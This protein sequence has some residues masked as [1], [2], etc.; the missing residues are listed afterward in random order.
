MDYPNNSYYLN[1]AFG[2][3]FEVRTGLSRLGVAR[4]FALVQSSIAILLGFSFGILVSNSIANKRTP[5]YDESLV[6]RLFSEASPAVVE[7]TVTRDNNNQAY[8]A[9]G[10]GSGFLIDNRGHILTNNHVIEGADK[11]RVNTS[12]GR[13]LTATL[14]GISPADD[15]ALIQVDPSDLGNILRLKLADS[16]KVEAGQMGIVSGTDRGSISPLSKPIPDMIQTDAALN[17]GN[18]DGPLL[19]SNGEVIGVTSAVRTPAIQG[20]GDFSIGFAR[21][22]ATP[23]PTYCLTL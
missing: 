12:E 17:P 16:E 11:I 20:I 8:A 19:N 7:I 18:S 6:T 5:L 23:L 21:C 3:A 22:P 15:L 14:L 10:T 4:S 13:T 2:A 9:L 1:P